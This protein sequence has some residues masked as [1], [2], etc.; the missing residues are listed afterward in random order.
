MF[1]SLM[2]PLLSQHGPSQSPPPPHD[3]LWLGSQYGLEQ[4]LGYPALCS[5]FPSPHRA[6]HQWAI[7]LCRAQQFCPYHWDGCLRSTSL[8]PEVVLQVSSQFSYSAQGFLNQ[9]INPAL[10]W[11]SNMPPWAGFIKTTK[12]ILKQSSENPHHV[13][14]RS[15][16][17]WGDSQA[18]PA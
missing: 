2:A 1:S 13:H 16:S 4:T 10:L 7:A 15:H 11:F 18:F 12:S 8:W 3:P 9:T 5:S 17:W 6:I 14:T